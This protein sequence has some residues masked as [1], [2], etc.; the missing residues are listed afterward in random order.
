VQVFKDLLEHGA[1]AKDLGGRWTPL[2]FAC[3]QEHWAIFNE[4]LSPNDSRDG[5]TTSILG[6]RKSRGGANIEPKDMN[7]CTPLHFASSKGHLLIVKALL[8][9]GANI[10]AANKQVELPVHEAVSRGHAAVAK[11]LLQHFY[12][13]THRLP[14]RELVEDLTW[15]G[16]PDSSDVPPLRFA[17][18]QDV[19]GTDDVVEILEYLVD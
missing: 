14:L 19:L 10:L 9:V 13:T 2:S 3:L 8:T 5:T 1:D 15:I 11:C 7:G 4:L 6:K 17:L 18:H 12:A 16:D